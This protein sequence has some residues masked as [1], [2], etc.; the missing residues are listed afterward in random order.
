MFSGAAL[1]LGFPL[2]I[3]RKKETALRSPAG[4]DDLFLQKWEAGQPGL[5]KQLPWTSTLNSPDPG[6]FLEGKKSS[7]E[8]MDARG[9]QGMLSGRDRDLEAGH[10]FLH[11]ISG[12]RTSCREGRRSCLTMALGTSLALR[13]SR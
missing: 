13:G 7:V 3:W 4:C 6:G 11:F 2:W 10:T 12:M 1:A 5:C 8:S 9:I